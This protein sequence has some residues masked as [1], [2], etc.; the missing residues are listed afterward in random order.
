M[1]LLRF[2]DL[3]ARLVGSFLLVFLLQIRFDGRPLESY[4]TK[5]SQNF[6]L[7]KTLKTVGG[8]GVKIVRG[9]SFD[10]EKQ[11]REIANKKAVKVFEDLKKRISLPEK[12]NK[13]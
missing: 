4:L 9:L 1:I 8:D 11:N 5:F 3:L 2:F 7:T 13:E 10:K 12:E 6:F